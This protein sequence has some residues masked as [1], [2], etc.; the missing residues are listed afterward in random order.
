MSLLNV[1]LN[2]RYEDG[3]NINN[4][5]FPAIYMVLYLSNKSIRRPPQSHETIP[6]NGV[7]IKIISNPDISLYRYVLKRLAYSAV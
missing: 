5:Y 2:F 7:R 1:M 6:L 3:F 4:K